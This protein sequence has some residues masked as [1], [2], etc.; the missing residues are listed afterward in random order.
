MLLLLLS[1]LFL[2]LFLLLLLS[3]DL[4]SYTLKRYLTLLYAV[5]FGTFFNCTAQLRVILY[6]IGKLPPWFTIEYKN[7]TKL[8]A[9]KLL[10]NCVWLSLSTCRLPLFTTPLSLCSH[11]FIEYS[12]CIQCCLMYLSLLDLS[13]QVPISDMYYWVDGITFQ[14]YRAQI[15][16]SYRADRLLGWTG[17]VSRW[18]VATATSLK[19]TKWELYNVWSV[20]IASLCLSLIDHKINIA[21]VLQYWGNILKYFASN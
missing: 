12:I 14:N 3:L 21:S 15:A 17:D 8:N 6:Y 4:T 1:F 11:I 20:Q 16:P 9:L 18:A 5:K 10:F 13:F 7:I 19:V 2:L